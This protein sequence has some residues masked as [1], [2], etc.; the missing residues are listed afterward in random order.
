MDTALSQHILL[1][2]NN[3]P[4]RP[5]SHKE[6][7][8]DWFKCLAFVSLSEPGG[9]KTKP[10]GA[11]VGERTTGLF[12]QP[13]ANSASYHLPSHDTPGWGYLARK[14]A[15]LLLPLRSDVAPLL[16]NLA[17][18][19]HF[20]LL[21]PVENVRI[22]WCHIIYFELICYTHTWNGCIQT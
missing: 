3:Y 20:H 9:F 16:V 21:S 13:S 7:G 5:L 12:L 22:A 8:H 11:S 10:E 2:F 15:F 1:H 18:P 17:S 6:I 4:T 14:T 19:F